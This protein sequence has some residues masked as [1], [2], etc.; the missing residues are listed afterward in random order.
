M[1]ILQLKG[2]KRRPA[3]DLAV[4]K[5]KKIGAALLIISEHNINAIKGRRN[6]FHDTRTKTAIHIVDHQIK[7][8]NMSLTWNRFH[9]RVNRKIDYL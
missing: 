7:I 5:A 9:V 4:A 1:K 8:T 2:N 6:W 3:Q